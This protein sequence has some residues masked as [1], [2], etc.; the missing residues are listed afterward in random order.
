MQVA[1][2]CTESGGGTAAALADALTKAALAAG[3]TDD[4]TVLAIKLEDLC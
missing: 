1:N 2:I 4:I 3:S